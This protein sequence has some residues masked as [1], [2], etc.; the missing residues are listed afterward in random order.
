MRTYSLARG[1][2]GAIIVT[3]AI[4]AASA[5]GASAA[6]TLELSSVA[7]LVNPGEETTLVLGQG[8]VGPGVQKAIRVETPDGNVTCETEPTRN[9]DELRATDVSNDQKTDALKLPDVANFNGDDACSSTLS[10]D[11]TAGIEWYAPMS[12][13]SL[14]TLSLGANHKA[15]LTAPAPDV[16]ALSF[17]SGEHC[18][19]TYSKLKGHL[20]AGT[21]EIQPEFAKQKLKEMTS[22]SS[23]S[24]PSKAKLTLYVFYV[25][26]HTNDVV[27]FKVN[28]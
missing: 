10:G 27:A 3:A 2:A 23:A 4:V 28:S 8:D 6:S 21:N 15:Q 11:P 7:G 12:P 20:H 24:C 18:L 26:T 13:F 16:I 19:Y 9:E 25:L 17:S 14:G 1:V 22:E 5:S